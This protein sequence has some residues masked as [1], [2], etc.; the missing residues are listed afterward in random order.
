LRQDYRGGNLSLP[1]HC[2]AHNTATTSS[3]PR[4]PRRI[5]AQV[6]ATTPKSGRPRPGQ[7]DHVYVR[8]TTTLSA[9]RDTNSF[10]I[11][12]ALE[13]LSAGYCP[14]GRAGSLT[15]TGTSLLDYERGVPVAQPHGGREARKSMSR[16]PR[17]DFT[18]VRATT[19][20]PGQ[21][22]LTVRQTPLR[23]RRH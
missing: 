18:H 2:L 8:A 6:R 3:T 1:L 21:P 17:L 20:T 11:P 22:R 4:R 10:P 19:P 9:I 7:G 15:S 13:L 16:R 23:V 14:T 12:C 5:L